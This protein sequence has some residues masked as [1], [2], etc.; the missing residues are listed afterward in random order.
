M[1]KSKVM[2]DEQKYE[3]LEFAKKLALE[4]GEIMRKYFLVTNTT[5]KSDNTPL[6]Q[7]DT[8]INL[9]VI[10]RINDEYPDHSI[11]GEEESDMRSS[12]YVWVCDPVDGTMPYSHGLPI[13]TFSLALCDDGTPQVGVVY[14]PFMKRLFWA[15]TGGGAYCNGDEM[16]VNAGGFEKSLISLDAFPSTKPVIK[17]SSIIRDVL[18]ERGAQTVTLWSSILPAV[19][20]ASGEFSAAILNIPFPQ[21]P[22][23]VKVIVEEAG[24]RVTDLFGNDQQYDRPTKGFIA[25][26]GVIHDELVNLVKEASDEV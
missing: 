3:Y 6:T 17:A 16:K 5:W 7:A 25:S 8:E 24:G 11:L 22:A 18:F 14:D 13:S 9:L 20:I 1:E 4:A 21:D 12:R 10:K 19:L 15:T 2:S 23:A 26:N